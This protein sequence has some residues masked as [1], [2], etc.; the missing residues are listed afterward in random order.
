MA[1]NASVLLGD[2]LDLA[3]DLPAAS[4]DL[5]YADPPFNTGA[6]KRTPPNAPKR[7]GAA[8]EGASYED[9]WPDTAAYIAVVRCGWSDAWGRLVG[10][11]LAR[12]P[13]SASCARGDELIEPQTTLGLGHGVFGC[14]VTI[15]GDLVGEFMLFD[16]T[17]IA[18]GLGRSLG[19]A[20]N[21]VVHRLGHRVHSGKRLAV[22]QF[23]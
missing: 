9:S 5:L 15:G 1:V 16:T 6:T 21:R 7:A 12:R 10:G 13:E 11:W 19:V 23:R 4:I 17:G 22:D 2:W 18:R 3:T 8:A 20:S 14:E